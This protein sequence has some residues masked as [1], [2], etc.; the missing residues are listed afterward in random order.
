MSDILEDL[1]G[2][3]LQALRA[4]HAHAQTSATR[5]ALAHI[6]GNIVDLSSKITEGTMEIHNIPTENNP[7]PIVI[8]D[9]E[10]TPGNI[11]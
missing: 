5:S 6:V 3:Y 1:E 9:E 11:S 8:S 2:K 10:D 7:M 4:E